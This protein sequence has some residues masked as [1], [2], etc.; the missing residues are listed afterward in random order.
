MVMTGQVKGLNARRLVAALVVLGQ[1]VCAI[2]YAQARQPKASPVNEHT[3]SLA[4]YFDWVNRNWYGS[5]E[6]R[7][8]A[9]LGFFKW[10]CAEYGMRLDVA[11]SADLRLPA[12]EGLGVRVA[13]RVR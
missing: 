12:D 3:P 9:N 5:S 11:R 8:L 10:M 4:M 2:A 7:V 6:S 1:A 13:T